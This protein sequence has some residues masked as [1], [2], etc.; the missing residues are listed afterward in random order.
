MF[1]TVAGNHII[2]FWVDNS[3]SI[4]VPIES[5]FGKNIVRVALKIAFATE[6]DRLGSRCVISRILV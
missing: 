6:I 1:S 2:P 3:T 4:C 5:S